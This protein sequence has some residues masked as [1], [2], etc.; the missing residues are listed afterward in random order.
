M[1]LSAVC[2]GVNFD[3]TQ[4]PATNQH[5]LKLRHIFI[6]LSSQSNLVGCYC[7]H[8]PSS[9][10]ILLS[11]KANIHLI[12]RQGEEGWIDQGV[13]CVPK[14][15][16]CNG[17]H[18]KVPLWGFIAGPCTSHSDERNSICTTGTWIIRQFYAVTLHTTLSQSH[19][20]EPIKKNEHTRTTMYTNSQTQ[21][22]CS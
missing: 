21:T 5:L 11:L 14:A 18:D 12:F 22:S 16:Y 15:V 17:C 2:Y 10:F 6:L 20:F 7:L 13:Q 19:C 8:R 9:L 1:R 4:S 3:H